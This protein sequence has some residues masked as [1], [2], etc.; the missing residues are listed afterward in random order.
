M[1]ETLWSDENGS[2][3]RRRRRRHL[4]R[5]AERVVKGSP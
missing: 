4:A 2:C 1:G 5:G 3:R